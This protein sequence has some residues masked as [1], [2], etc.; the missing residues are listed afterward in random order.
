MVTPAVNTASVIITD[1]MRDAKLLAKGKTP[2]SDDFVEYGRKLLKYISFLQTQGMKLWLLSDQAITMTAGKGG[3]GNPYQLK[4]GGDVDMTK[5]LQ[6]LQGYYLYTVGT[7]RAITSL[8]Y[9]EWLLLS[10]TNTTGLVSQY[11]VDKQQTSLNVYTW[12]IPDSTEASGGTL[13][14]LLRTQVTQFTNL[15][16]TL[17][18]PIEW[19]LTLEWGL[20][21]E[22]CSGQPQAVIQLCQ[23]NA[24]KYR[25]A[26]EDWDVEDSPTVFQLDQ[27]MFQGDRGNFA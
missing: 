5:P 15:T 9:N 2:S 10:P 14:V 4:P 26:L 13:H 6:V 17:A 3:I 8:S 27:R 16:D 11:F 23:G 18:F 1:A 24:E 20:A 12:L 22:I 7:R 25:R 21:A 19:A